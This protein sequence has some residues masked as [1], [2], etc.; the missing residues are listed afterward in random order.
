MW[1]MLKAVHPKPEGSDDGGVVATT[2]LA[3]LLGENG[4]TGVSLVGTF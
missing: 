1:L 2:Q 4:E 3:P